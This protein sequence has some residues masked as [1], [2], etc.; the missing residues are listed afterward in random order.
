M[1]SIPTRQQRFRGCLLGQAVGGV[2][3]ANQ[4]SHCLQRLAP[5]ALFYSDEPEKLLERASL[6]SSERDVADACRYFAGLLV[7][8]VQG[9]SKKTIL[10]PLFTPV[11]GYWQDRPLSQPVREIAEGSFKHRSAPDAESTSDV[12]TLRTVLWAFWRN[13]DFTAGLGDVGTNGAVYGQL[14]GAYYGAEAIPQ[15]CLDRIADR[16]LV[17][18][19]AD[20]LFEAGA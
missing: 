3:G 18:D 4:A 11:R 10:A 14:A 20:R 1:D 16:Q 13:D 15:D 5:L 9:V 6:T 17:E 7:G 19:L 12:E 8:A 2:T